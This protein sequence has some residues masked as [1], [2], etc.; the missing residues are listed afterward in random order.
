MISFQSDQ[1]QS[2]RFVKTEWRFSKEYER[3][4]KREKS[5]EI[6]GKN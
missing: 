6:N 4:R 5:S 1:I 3:K 2:F